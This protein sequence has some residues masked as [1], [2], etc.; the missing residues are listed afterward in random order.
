[1][2]PMKP[3]SAVNTKSTLSVHSASNNSIHESLFDIDFKNEIGDM[4]EDDSDPSSAAISIIANNTNLGEEM[5]DPG[6]S[7]N[8]GTIPELPELGY[9]SDSSCDT[10]LLLPRSNLVY[11]AFFYF[12]MIYYNR[13]N[14]KKS[15]ERSDEKLGEKM[16]DTVPE[17]SGGDT[18]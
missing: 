14:G 11:D 15:Q 4:E 12:S 1:M 7:G 6:F 16:L 3:I 13:C 17:E 10:E 18:T 8:L 9:Q 2:Q 5:E